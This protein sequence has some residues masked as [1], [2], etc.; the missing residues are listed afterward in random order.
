M[1]RPHLPGCPII[2]CKIPFTYTIFT[3]KSSQNPLYFHQLFVIFIISHLHLI[4]HL[5]TQNTMTMNTI[6]Y[7]LFFHPSTPPLFSILFF[8]LRHY[9]FSVF[10]FFFISLYY[11]YF[12]RPCINTCS[13]YFPLLTFEYFNTCKGFH[14]SSFF[15]SSN[16]LLINKPSKNFVYQE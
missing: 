4:L 1:N 16:K 14:L 10:L 13:Y 8:F 5:Q 7:C 12:Y 15:S 6:D 2:I 9:I 3:C 11:F